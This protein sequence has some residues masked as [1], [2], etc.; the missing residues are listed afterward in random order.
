MVYLTI[1]SRK[2]YTLVWFERFKFELN[3]LY[4]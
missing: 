1:F 2:L 4:G 3:S